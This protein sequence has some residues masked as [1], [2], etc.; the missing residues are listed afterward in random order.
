MNGFRNALACYP[1]PS[2]SSESG[3]TPVGRRKSNLAVFK[4][5]KVAKLD[6]LQEYLNAPPAPDDTDVLQWWKERA[7]TYPRLAAMAR[8]YLAIPAT[9]APVERVFSGGMNL[10]QPKR[11]A[12]A[13]REVY[14]HLHVP[15]GLVE[16]AALI[17]VFA[18]LVD[19]CPWSMD[20]HAWSTDAQK[21][22]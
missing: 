8:D 15:E 10:V 16:A 12:L 5:R 3:R 18:C 17:C 19:C 14:P 6:E 2:A 9:G 20:I 13:E 21:P 7:A 22:C 11:G 1:D 4:Y